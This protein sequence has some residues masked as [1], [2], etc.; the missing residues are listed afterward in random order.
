MKHIKTFQNFE[1][2]EGVFNEPLLNS[3]Y[4]DVIQKLFDMIKKTYSVENLNYDHSS[5]FKIVYNHG[6]VNLEIYSNN[7]DLYVDSKNIKCSYLL[8]YK[9]YHY[10]K[11]K[12]FSYKKEK[13]RLKDIS[14]VD[15]LTKKIKEG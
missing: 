4:D 14:T 1:L 8:R 7:Y 11:N 13:Q 9:I 3:V 5:P 6:S 2:N 10:F 15:Y 12:F